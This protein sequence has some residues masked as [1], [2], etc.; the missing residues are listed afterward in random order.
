[1]LY[2]IGDR[3]YCR[4]NSDSSVIFDYDFYDSR[5]L[6]FKIRTFEVI[7]IHDIFY[8]ILCWPG[9][10]DAVL[11]NKDR[12][13]KWNI[14]PKHLGRY[15]IFVREFSIGGRET[16]DYYKNALA[17]K[18]CKEY[19]PYAEPNQPDGSLVCWVCRTTRIIY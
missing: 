19:Y 9:V 18:V 16:I 5:Y 10:D 15:G 12:I 4:I 11:L 3:V 17:C 1:M 14:N 7:G 13:D 8:V 2:H 6:Q